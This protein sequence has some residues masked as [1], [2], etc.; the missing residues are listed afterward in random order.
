MKQQEYRSEEER[1]EDRG[2]EKG[3]NTDAL[4]VLR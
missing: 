3:G 4:A 2:K 1:S